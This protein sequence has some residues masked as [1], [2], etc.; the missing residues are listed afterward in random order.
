MW[1]PR[2]FGRK[3]KF[4]QQ[5][6]TVR[7]QIRPIMPIS[8]LTY[9]LDAEGTTRDNRNSPCQAFQ[10]LLSFMY[11]TYVPFKKYY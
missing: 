4:P 10:K 6:K 11:Y 5:W 7:N 8:T 1:E 9:E 3:K 2:T